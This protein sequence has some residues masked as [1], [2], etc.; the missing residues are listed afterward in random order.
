MSLGKDYLPEGTTEILWMHPLDIDFNEV[1]SRAKTKQYEQLLY[2]SGG[3]SGIRTVSC[4]PQMTPFSDSKDSI[5]EYTLLVSN[6]DFD[7]EAGASASMLAIMKTVQS[8]YF[9]GK[10]THLISQNKKTV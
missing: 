10:I 2:E 3:I 7:V 5:L 9:L 8:L 4:M 1:L 6:I